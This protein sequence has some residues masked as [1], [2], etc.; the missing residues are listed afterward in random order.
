MF[1]EYLFNFPSL[2]DSQ[3]IP[4]SLKS[5]GK[6]RR[7]TSGND[8]SSPK[9]RKIDPTERSSTPTTIPEDRSFSDAETSTAALADAKNG[10]SKKAL[11]QMIAGA[12]EFTPGQ[13]L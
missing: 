1:A 5:Q 3:K 10:E 9:R 2:D 12:T 13:S 7:I 6:K 11:R 4:D 8:Q